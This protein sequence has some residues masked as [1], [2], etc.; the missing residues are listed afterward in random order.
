MRRSLRAA[1]LLVR[2]QSLI[3]SAIS[4]A[5]KPATLLYQSTFLTF[6]L[7]LLLSSAL[8]YFAAAQGMEVS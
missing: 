3:V 1:S 4:D 5:L 2:S 7:S 6:F 8:L